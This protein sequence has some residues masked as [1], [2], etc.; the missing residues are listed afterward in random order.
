MRKWLGI[1]FL[2]L[3]LMGCMSC[4][5]AKAETE[6]EL[7][8]TIIEQLEQ[9]DLQALQKYVDSLGN[10]TN[11][12]VVE[13]L[14]AYIGGNELDYAKM[15][16]QFGTVLFAKVM[17]IFPVFA[18][19]TAIALLSGLLSTMRGDMIVRTTSETMFLITYAAALVPLVA[20]LT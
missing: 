12:S 8:Q 6:E 2:A 1:I 3:C 10:F 11:E 15:A 13:R 16:E 17:E 18:C 19:I 14:L 5:T 7:N 20:V 4:I 9:L